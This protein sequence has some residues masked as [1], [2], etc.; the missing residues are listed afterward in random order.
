MARS[1]S[2]AAQT[3]REQ[4]EGQAGPKG[5]RRLQRSKCAILVQKYRVGA[6]REGCSVIP[7]GG[8]PMSQDSRITLRS[9]VNLLN[10][11]FE[12]KF[13]CCLWQAPAIL[14]DSLSSC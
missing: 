4:V 12:F 10:L 6:R 11:N 5:R 7:M 9:S 8:S 14:A 3:T 1:S 13:N 2:L